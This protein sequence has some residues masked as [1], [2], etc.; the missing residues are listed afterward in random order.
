MPT[1]IIIGIVISYFGIQETQLNTIK[2]SKS[3]RFLSSW[4][5]KPA[6]PNNIKVKRKVSDIAVGRMYN[7]IYA[8]IL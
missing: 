3:C 4:G 8:A 5:H 6:P 1:T 2:V 7:N